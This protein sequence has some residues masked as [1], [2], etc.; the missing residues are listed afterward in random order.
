MNEAPTATATRR[1]AIVS[2]A[3]KVFAAHG[4]DAGT[5]REIAV[6]AGVAEGLIYHYF[7]SKEALLD[8]VIRERSIL[9]WLDEPE[10]LPDDLPVKD[11]LRQLL[12]EALSRLSRH[13]DLF[14]VVWSQV[15]TNRRLADRVGRFVR[16]VT[17]RIAAYLDRKIAR[18][19]LRP[20]DTNVAA[21]LVAGSLVTF[22]IMQHRLSPPLK[23]VEPE[24]FADQLTDI[25]LEGC[26]TDASSTGARRGRKSHGKA[27]RTE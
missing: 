23:Y 8:A 19:E 17:G 11:A 20:I 16:E 10:A 21:R 2:A 3:L 14:A 5:I 7:D 26:V 15:A 22:T 27:D 12:A 1:S 6:E 24:H 18:G 13:A 4:F 9:P 25:L